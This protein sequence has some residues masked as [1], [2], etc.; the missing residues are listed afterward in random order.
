MTGFTITANTGKGIKTDVSAV[1]TD[2]TD[3]ATGK[4]L[5]KIPYNESIDLTG[6]SFTA[7]IPD[8]H[9]LDP[10]AGT[11]A[12]DITTKQFAL[13]K[14]DTGSQR[15]YT[16]EVVKGPYI[17]AF[18]FPVSNTGVTTEVTGTIDHIAGTIS[19][20]VPSG[21]ILSGLTPTITVGDNTKSEFTPFAQAD[22][23]SNVEY[24]VTSSNP[25]ATDFTKV[26]TVIVTQNTA[27]QI[28]SFAFTN[29]DKNL[30]NNIGVEIKHSEG[31]IIVKV[32][33]NAD[34]N[35]LVPTITAGT[36]PSGTKIYKGESGITSYT[37]PTD[38]S[39]SHDSSVKYS[40]AGPAGGRKVYSV[41]VYKEP[42]I[43]GFSFTKAQ[44]T[45]N[46][47]FPTGQTYNGNVSGNTI[48]VTVAN[49]VDV[50]NL[51]ASI[52]GSNI[53]ANYVTSGLNFTT[54]GG[55][56][57]IEVP[58][59]DLPGYTKTYIVTLTKEAASKLTGFTITANTGK[60]IKTDVSAVIT[61]DTDTA[62]GKILLKIP[63][64]ESI[65]LT[66]L[67]FTAIIPD[68]HTLDP[69]AGAIAEDIT[70]KQFA[71][72][73]TDTG[74]QRGY[75]V[76]VVKGPYISAFKFPASN[77]G[78]NTDISATNI[79][80]DTG[81]ITIIVPNGVT[82]SNLTPTIAVGEN[83]KTDFTP[84]AQTDFSSNVEYTVTSSNP[85][86]TDFTKVY[87]VT[88]T[89]NAEP[90]ISEFKFLNSN[91]SSKNLVGDIIGD[92]NG[93]DIIVKVPHNTELNDLTPTVTAK[94]TPSGIQVYKGDTGTAPY[95]EAA[96]FTNSHDGSVKY[97]AVGS[98]GGRKVYSVKV[99]KEPAISEFK[100]ESSNNSGA[101]FPSGKTYT[102][103][104]T[105]NTIAVTVANTVDVANLKATITGSNIAAN[106]VI[107]NLNFSSGS[108][109]VTVANEHLPSY[110]KEY[111]VTVTKEAAPKLTEF[112]ITADATKGI[113]SEVKAT[114]THPSDDSN[115]GTIELKFPKDSSTEINLDGL[116]YTN[117]PIAG[118][119]LTPGTPVTRSIHNQQF[120][121]TTTL[122]SKSVYTVTAVKGPFIKSFKFEDSQNSK[123]G[124][125]SSSPIEGVINHEANTITVTL[126]ATVKKDSDGNNKVTL[127]PTIEF[128]GD[129]ATTVSP[130]TETST[131]FTS[132]TPVDY[133]TTANGMTKT[134]QV[135][136]TRTPS[137]EVKITKF[138]IETNNLGSISETGT[139]AKGRIVVP[140][141][142]VPTNTTPTIE[143]SDYSTVSP[144]GAQT[145][146][147]YDDSKEYTVT[148]EDATTTKT[149][150]VYIYDNAKTITDS[151][152]L[153]VEKD[154]TEITPSSKVITENSRVITVT[155][156]SS[157]TNE[158]LKALTLTFDTT[159]SS[160]S[161]SLTLTADPAASG[162]DFSDGKEVKYTL[163][164]GNDVKGHY[165]VKVAA[166]GS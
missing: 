80:H 59:Q 31:E 71:L 25:S 38:F 3:T 159:T 37:T 130:N 73:K 141:A 43:T 18:K 7:I 124:I 41:K 53:A 97:S 101:D 94:S 126:P 65:D 32:P 62:T 33:H 90:A 34:L 109:T 105:D 166:T 115:T 95:T 143:K 52:I 81:K 91:N 103:T 70:T 5:L 89:Q 47:G 113:V 63:Y 155:V 8:N 36:V 61:D 147:S 142:T 86:A 6:L 75:T 107:S 22:F 153:K 148:A 20:T 138:E 16:V 150:D 161:S 77:S 44:N 54:S 49:T 50:A 129:S 151:D 12:E 100:F 125:N 24:T 163:K 152:T 85:S 120:T 82:L 21:V 98:A 15:G 102:G 2:D 145:F 19:V 121:L 123:K 13:I 55:T 149:Y 83:T 1:I 58:N 146:S 136:V 132:G 137:V 27:P 66:G 88:V 4:I 72:I 117:E 30:G 48:T 76:E 23:S 140:V 93:S 68:N 17:S 157:T 162:Q 135:T 84:S 42:V 74:S 128:G 69:V 92:I 114:F 79:N 64:N 160:S 39:N 40:V 110:T 156:P 87:T 139:G 158:Q 26:Y 60:G 9:T 116:S 57:T 118:C 96:D 28:Q 51:K 154:G 29:T 106:L 10:V 122:G 165:W 133:T 131:Q 111:T 134:Y 67:S 144:N 56:L 35:G 127:T 46:I 119:T 112:K 164:E 78:I 104:V 99:Y 11:I 108:A 14:T 45:D